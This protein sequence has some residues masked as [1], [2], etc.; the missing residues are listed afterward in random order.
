MISISRAGSRFRPASCFLI[1]SCHS[2]M[3]NPRDPVNGFDK[4]PP[5][6]A[7]CRQD[8][9]ALLGQL[10]IAPSSLARLFDPSP[11][12]PPALFE[13]VQQRIE[14]RDVEAEHSIRARLY[15]F[16]DFVAV[17]GTGF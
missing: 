4:S 14:G 15:Q 12:Y 1:S 16:A 10:V 11:L 3:F 8:L 17:T 7:L 13:P 5:T 6:T 2:S 9:F